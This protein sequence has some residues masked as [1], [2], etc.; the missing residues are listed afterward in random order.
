MKYYNNGNDICVIV[1]FYNP[2]PSQVA[3]FEELSQEGANVI[4]VDNSKTAL[5]LTPDLLYIPL[6]ENKGIATAQNI[7]IRKAVEIGYKYIVF[8]DQDSVIRYDF[9]LCLVVC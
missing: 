7:G 1:V 9:L 4:I 3:N 2:T 8:S 6:R 5:S